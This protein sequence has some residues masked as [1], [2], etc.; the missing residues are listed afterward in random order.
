M[1]TRGSGLVKKLM[2]RKVKARKCKHLGV[3]ASRDERGRRQGR[4]SSLV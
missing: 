4:R 1:T 2:G 3:S